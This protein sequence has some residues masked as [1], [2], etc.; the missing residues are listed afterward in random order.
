MK[1]HEA[2]KHWN[3]SK[4][5]IDASHVWAIPRRGTPEH[6]DVLEIIQKAKES[7]NKPDISDFMKGTH[8]KKEKELA[9]PRK[10][11]LAQIMDYVQGVAKT[12][13]LKK[14]W[15]AILALDPELSEF[16]VTTRPKL[17][18]AIRDSAMINPD[19]GPL[20]ADMLRPKLI[21]FYG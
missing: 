20:V 11:T 9:A 19:V 14:I 1:W 7:S 17:V 12:A 5:K 6:A 8:S 2:L 16:K 15:A 13:D 4:K 3:E 18:S 10:F 21:E